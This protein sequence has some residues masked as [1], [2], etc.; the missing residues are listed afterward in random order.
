[1]AQ[2]PGR[3]LSAFTFELIKHYNV[4]LRF[5]FHTDIAISIYI[6]RRKKYIAV[7]WLWFA[8]TLVPMIGLVQ[9]GDQAMA[10]R[11]MYLSMLGLLIII[12]LEGKSLSRRTAVKIFRC[13][14]SRILLVRLRGLT[15]MQ[16][17]DWRNSL[18]LFEHTLKLQK[19]TQA[20]KTAMDAPCSITTASVKQNSI[21]TMP[22]V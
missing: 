11:Y 10:N 16:V 1:M 3:F 22:F 19:T 9:V 5:Y 12:A 18:T 14:I 13:G 17:Q 21:L 8:G 20:R 4:D 2:R 15:R 7:G 6:G